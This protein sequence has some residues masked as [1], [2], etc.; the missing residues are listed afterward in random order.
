MKVTQCNVQKKHTN[1]EN[2]MKTKKAA[3][4]KK[5]EQATGTALVGSPSAEEI[6]KHGEMLEAKRKQADVEAKQKA[7]VV[8]YCH[9][10]IAGTAKVGQ[11][12]L[13]LCKYIR[14]QQLM[15]KQVSAWLGEQ[16]FHKA[17]I[18]EINKVANAADDVWSEYAASTIGFRKT[19]E[20]TR[21]NVVDVVAE[22]SGTERSEVASA[23][24]E[25]SDTEGAGG[26]KG[27]TGGSEPETNVRK[28]ERLCAQILKLAAIEKLRSKKVNILNGYYIQIVKDRNWKAPAGFEP[29]KTSTVS[30]EDVQ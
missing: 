6:Q 2:K 22:V 7:Q 15:P 16:G 14:E 24:Q 26:G 27:D 17:R 20:L 18:S 11:Y 30:A 29:Q 1:Q 9:D 21:G 8:A 3:L 4:T 5:I 19:L 13:A 25:L 12:F 10:I 28:I 23:M